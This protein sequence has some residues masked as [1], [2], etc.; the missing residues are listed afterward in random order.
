MVDWRKFEEDFRAIPDPFSQM[1]VDWTYGEGQPENWTIAAWH[2]R[3]SRERFEAIARMAGQM[4]LSSPA[5]VSRCTSDL[6]NEQNPLHC[7]FMA[8]RELTDCFR[9][10]P[11]FI[12]YDENQKPVGRVYTGSIESVL[13][14]SALACLELASIETSFSESDADLASGQLEASSPARVSEA[15]TRT[16]TR[17]DQL[18]RRAKNHPVISIVL[19]LVLLLIGLGTLTNSLDKV[20]SFGKKY[21]F[22]EKQVADEKDRSFTKKGELSAESIYKDTQ[23]AKIAQQE[24]NKNI[25]ADEGSRPKIRDYSGNLITPEDGKIYTSYATNGA[26][27]DCMFQDDRIS[28][29]Y[30]SPDGK[31]T[32]YYVLDWKGN[33]IDHKLPY[34]LEEYTVLIPKDLEIGRNEIYLP[35]GHKR[36]HIKLKWGQTFD[37]IYDANGKL[38]QVSTHGGKMTI[39]NK[40]KTIKPALRKN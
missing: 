10:G 38:Q 27:V 23:G 30:T 7:W 35:N 28:V 5:V 21:I 34:K 32:A 9:Q 15:D 17:L 31:I 25:V 37:I 19:F 13:E 6:L 39:S 20:I 36:V 3:F 14:A 8:I 18:V 12:E 11:T 1:R 29:N 22:Q 24:I 4:L 26:K 16:Q 40:H 2:D 33:I